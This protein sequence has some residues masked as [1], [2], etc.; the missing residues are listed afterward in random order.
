MA[1]ALADDLIDTGECFLL[2]S[3]SGSFVD[4]KALSKIFGGTGHSCAISLG[5]VSGIQEAQV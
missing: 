5:K 3:P 4:S 2:T 1:R